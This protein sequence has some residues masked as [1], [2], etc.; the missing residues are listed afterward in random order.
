VYVSVCMDVS[1]EV[2]KEE[3]RG[4]KSEKFNVCVSQSE[5]CVCV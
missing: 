2:R 4:R 3:G 1:V 5:E